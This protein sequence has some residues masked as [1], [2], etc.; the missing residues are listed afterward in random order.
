MSLAK[1]ISSG[2]G[3][4]IEQLKIVQTSDVVA[5]AMWSSGCVV[6]RYIASCSKA[7]MN[8]SHGK[9]R[10]KYYLSVGLE[11]LGLEECTTT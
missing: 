2:S 9:T 4:S 11:T 3:V 10:V 5:T 6:S 1:N 7:F 8:L